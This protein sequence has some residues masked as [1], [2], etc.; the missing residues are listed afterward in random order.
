MN[1]MASFRGQ[2]Q[3][4]TGIRVAAV[5]DSRVLMSSLA[6]RVPCSDD[7]ITGERYSPLGLKFSAK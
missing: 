5:S 2:V 7:Y 4:Y 6:T 1:H 3:R